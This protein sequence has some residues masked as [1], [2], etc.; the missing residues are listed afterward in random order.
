MNPREERL[1]RLLL[2]PGQ[3]LV[4]HLVGGALD[5]CER[6]AAPLAHIEIVEVRVEALIDP[7]LGIEDVGS[8][9]R[10]GSVATLL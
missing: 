10:A 3:R 5:P 9:E 7:P 8:D 2:N 6:E 4:H 1:L